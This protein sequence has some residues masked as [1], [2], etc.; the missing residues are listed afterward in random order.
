M[1]DV[2]D[3]GD[4]V[5]AGCQKVWKINE[6]QAKQKCFSEKLTFFC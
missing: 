1:A 3:G 5:T 2:R 4:V 6:N